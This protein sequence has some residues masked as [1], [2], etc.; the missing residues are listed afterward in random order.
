[1]WLFELLRACRG[2]SATRPNFGRYSRL[3]HFFTMS[4]G[5]RPQ[6]SAFKLRIFYSMRMSILLTVRSSLFPSITKPTDQSKP[7]CPYHISNVTVHKRRQIQRR[8]RLPDG[9][10]GENR[11][12]EPGPAVDIC[13]EEVQSRDCGGGARGKGQLHICERRCRHAGNGALSASHTGMS[14][15]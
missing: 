9:I 5:N 11:C 2:A 1:M 14:G 6:K 12:R 8:A 7:C 4:M 15:V 3:L 10:H 13:R